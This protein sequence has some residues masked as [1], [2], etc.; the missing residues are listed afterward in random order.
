M[1]STR[2]PSPKGDRVMRTDRH[3]VAV[4]RQ[5]SETAGERDPWHHV[6]VDSVLELDHLRRAAVEVSEHHAHDLRVIPLG[7]DLQVVDP[8]DV[9]LIEQRPPGGA[10]NALAHDQRSISA[11]LL[12]VLRIEGRDSLPKAASPTNS[13]VDLYFGLGCVNGAT[14]RDHLPVVGVVPRQFVEV[15]LHRFDNQSGEPM[16]GDRAIQVIEADPIVGADLDEEEVVSRGLD[17]FEEEGMHEPFV[18]QL[19]VGRSIRHASDHSKQRPVNGVEA[20]SASTR[21]SPSG[22]PRREHPVLPVHVSLPFAV[23]MGGDCGPT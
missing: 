14:D 13:T 2:R 11:G 18:V 8:I 6:L 16:T 9:V 10:R 5:G 15:F 21:P 23:S 1:S 12:M 17:C 20:A 4:V 22:A 19:G 3:H 7:V